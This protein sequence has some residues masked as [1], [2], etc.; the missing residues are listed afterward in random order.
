MESVVILTSRIQPSFTVKFDAMTGTRSDVPGCT[1]SHGRPAFV[2]NVEVFLHRGDRWLLIRRGELEKH[3]PGTL[4]G[5]GGKV[6]ADIVDG[7]LG[8][9]VLEATARREVAEEIG[10]DLAGS[11]LSYVDSAAFVTDDDDPVINVVFVG[12]MPP[13]AEPFAASPAEV[14]EIMWLSLA[15]AERDPRCPQWT[16]RS[17][18]T[19]TAL[20]VTRDVEPSPSG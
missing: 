15:D 19:A 6:D 1:T 9:G 8:A 10:V 16:L 17:L 2:V 11:Q 14:A 4:C 7:G 5:V 20:S 18:R 3:A 12:P 13:E